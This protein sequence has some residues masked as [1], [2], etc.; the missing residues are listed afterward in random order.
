MPGPA[1]REKFSCI[2]PA[3]IDPS[4]A[5]QDRAVANASATLSW[6]AVSPVTL[7]CTTY[8]R[9]PLSCAPNTKTVSG[10]ER[11]APQRIAAARAHAGI[12]NADTSDDARAR[13]REQA[14][15]AARNRT[16][17][18]VG[19]RQPVRTWCGNRREI[20]HGRSGYVPLTD[21]RKNRTRHR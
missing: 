19:D 12:V 11:G 15:T 2:Q 18:S 17:L 7:L 6:S 9:R 20:G 16:V 1:V 5:S 8:W 14:E 4:L 10:A 21:S 3:S 13:S